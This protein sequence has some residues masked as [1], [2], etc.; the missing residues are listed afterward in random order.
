MHIKTN[1]EHNMIQ[2]I[3]LAICPLLLVVNTVTQAVFFIFATGVCFIV[4][5]F[6]CGLFNRYFSKNIKIFVTAVLSSF[7]IAILDF[8]LK[9]EPKFGLESNSDCFYAVLSV[10]CLCLDI[11]CID[12]KSIV[13][14]HMIKTFIT[15]GIFAGILLVYGMIIEIL[16]YGSFFGGK[17]MEGNEFFA[18]ITFKFILLGILTV[19]ADYIYRYYQTKANE[20]KMAYEKYVRKIRDEKLFQYDELRRKKLL[21]S[22]I[23]INNVKEDFIQI[24]EQKNAENE[25][26]EEDI[27]KSLKQ[28]EIKKP[29]ENKKNKSKNKKVKNHINVKV[30]EKEKNSKSVNKE[31]KVDEG[32]NEKPKGKAKKSKKRGKAK[33]ERIFGSNSNPNGDKKN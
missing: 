21:T 24:I 32:L 27:K 5:A 8:L 15:T 3:I 14:L 16:G 6:V 23:E 28:S 1:I 10:I 30:Q 17:I 11:Y 25:S 7:I 12:S 18:S 26:V 33:V 19:V 31:E 9:K 13:K 2:I 29:V 20:K 22:K 4:S